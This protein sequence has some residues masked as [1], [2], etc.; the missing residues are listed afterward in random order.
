MRKLFKFIPKEVPE[1][2]KYGI[3]S[4]EEEIANMLSHGIG[5]VFF[6][7]ACPILIFKSTQSDLENFTLASIIFSISLLMVYTS[8]T[9]YHSVYKLK[10]RLRLRVFDHIS[11]YFLIAGSFTPFVLVMLKSNAGYWV[12]SILWIAVIIGTVFKYFFTHKFNLVSTLAY[13]AMGAM[14]LFVIEPLH[15]VLSEK[16]FMFL[17]IGLGSYLI[18]VP[19][20]LWK[21]LYFNHF[22]WHVFVLGGSFFSYLAIY[23]IG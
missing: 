4:M 9:T 22:I 21:K 12:L 18:G 3:K 23:Y 1:E 20:Y 2:L 15:E 11:I 10:L 17:A 19:F 6:I 7:L 13:V 14:A 16:S 5:L 8:S